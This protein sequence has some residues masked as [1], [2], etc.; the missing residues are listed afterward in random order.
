MSATRSIS[1][2]QSR[3]VEFLRR[4]EISDQTFLI[5]VSVVVGIVVGAGAFLF[6]KMLEY[7]THFF[8]QVLPAWAGQGNIWILFT[9]FL[10]A[11]LLGFFYWRFP[12]E[13][14]Q[15]GVPAT[16]EAVALRGGFIRWSN[17]ALCMLM[18][19]LTLG[20][21]GSAGS[22][23]P[24]IRIGSALASGI[25]QV[26]RVSG[27]RLRVLT[28]CGAAAGLAS[29][30]NAPIAGV[31]F[32][33]EV[34]LGEFNVH[35]FSPIVISSVVAT[36]FSRAF[37]HSEALLQLPAFELTSPWEI[38][39]YALMGIV[40]GLVSVAFTRS[41]HGMEHLFK[42][43]VRG[44]KA[45]KPA[46]GGFLVGIV[47]LFY[48][49]VF[50]YSYE[51][52][53][54]AINGQILLSTLFILVAVKI[55]ATAFTLGSGGSGGILCPS[56]FLGATLGSACGA[57]FHSWFP[58]IV[59]NQGPYGVVGMGALLGA[60]VQAPMT[61]IIMVFEMTNEYT[62][63]LPMMTSCILATLVHKSVL[64]G[65]IYSLSLSHNG[66]DI[67]AGREMGILSSL[68]VRDIMEDQS[69][70][71]KATA[72]YRSVI[73]ALLNNRGN[74]LYITDERDNLEGVISFSDLK[75][76]VFEEGLQD[77]VV[78][79]DLANREVLFVSPD[80][81]LAASINKFSFIDMEQLPVID[82]RNGTRKVLGVVTRNQLMKA[83]HH[84]MQKR[85][86]IQNEAARPEP[87]NRRTPARRPLKLAKSGTALSG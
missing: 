23:G 84:E 53:S 11:L 26:F 5:I 81:S 71:L 75:E 73:Q 69:G 17:S 6:E 27:N 78:A 12:K 39:L 58:A 38:C 54:Q 59:V 22:E 42:R 4:L 64:K 10:G 16:M 28:A 34:I 24:I 77:L 47:G 65:S 9:P 86:L 31:L 3:C 41:M 45:L 18:S 37:L 33:L 20:S 48:P 2:K 50:G 25:G 76:F 79:R 70:T 49:Q 21:G 60:V 74:Y 61:A 30:F 66:V 15:D 35:T 80:E 82:A 44:P 85:V 83:Y 32:S 46:L 1:L 43:Y 51:P 62:V 67:E 87:K 8:W 14:E 63:I 13:A 56:L 52:I 29:I 19:A 57:L 7:S 55:L 68:K 36:A 40:A 72:P